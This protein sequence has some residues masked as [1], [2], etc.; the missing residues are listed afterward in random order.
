[1]PA[2][3]ESNPSTYGSYARWHLLPL[4]AVRLTGGFWADRQV[5]N[6]QVS[7]NH[8]HRMLEEVGNFHNLRLAAGLAEGHFQGREF[9]DSDVYKW[10]E[11]A[12]YELHRHPDE[13]LLGKVDQA[14]D[15]IAAA[16]QADGYLN[17]YYQVAKP[18]ERWTD[19]DFGHE[20]YCAGHLF[21]AAVAH[22]QATNDPKLLAVATRLADYIGSVFGPD[23]RPG[24]PGHPEIEL[25]LVKLYRVTGNQAYLDLAGFFIDQR[26]QARMRGLGWLG[27]DYHQDRVPVREA[28]EIEGH[29]VRALYLTTGVT[30]VYRETG[31][32]ALLAALQRQWQDM[33]GGKLY[34]TGGVGAR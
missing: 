20:L 24:A 3:R 31:E 11:A 30:E 34:L 32:P 4:T 5:L 16:Q 2:Q 19:L 9:A 6:R 29:A 8:G 18:D 10:L 21:E 33:V 17:S 13:G 25:A 23:K 15:L 7:L 22:V 26:G 28:S 27:P 1:M 14:I 12:A